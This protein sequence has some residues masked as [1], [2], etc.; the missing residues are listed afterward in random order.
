MTDKK[1]SYPPDHFAQQVGAKAARKQRA[2]RHRST[3]WFGL[4]LMGLVGWSIAIPTVAGI[5]L[6]MWLDGN[7]PGPRS[8]TLTLLVAGLVLGCLNVWRWIA[9]EQERIRKEQE[10]GD[11]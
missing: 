6:G 10:N 2:R 7:H 4:G 1:Q 9:N 8:W 5:A 3:V 11:E